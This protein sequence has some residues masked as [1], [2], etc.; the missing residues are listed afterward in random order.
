MGRRA[1]KIHGKFNRRFW[2]KCAVLESI[3]YAS[4]RESMQWFESRK[5]CGIL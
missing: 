3:G 2:K 5:Q 1:L 4:L